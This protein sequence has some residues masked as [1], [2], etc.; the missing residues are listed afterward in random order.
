MTPVMTQLI[1]YLQPGLMRE[2]ANQTDADL[3]NRFVRSRDGLAF[4]LLLWRH[5]AMVWG[6]CRRILGASPDAEDAFQATFVILSRKA[7]TV[8]H[9]PALAGW[10][11][12]V[13]WRTASNARRARGR[14]RETSSTV[15]SFS[16]LRFD[17]VQ[18]AENAELAAIIDA[19]IARLPEP[20]RE[21]FVL[22]ELEGRPLESAARELAIPLGTLNSRL[23]RARSKLRERL[24]SRGVA[25]TTLAIAVVP[26]SMAAAT[27]NI[28]AN[29]I[30]A[31]AL[32]LAAGVSLFV[33]PKSLF[34][35]STTAVMMLAGVGYGAWE[36]VQTQPVPPKLGANEEVVNELAPIDG[37]V[38]AGALARLGSQRLRHNGRVSTMA[39]SP[40]GKLLA[41][42]SLTFE[43]ATA[44]LWDTQTGREVFRVKIDVGRKLI[45]EAKVPHAIG[46]ANGG[47]EFLVAD[48]KGFR[49]FDVT[50]R[51]E[52]FASDYYGGK[53]KAAEVL[54]IA[55]SPDGK[56]FVLT[57]EATGLLEIGDTATGTVLKSI[58]HP[59]ADQKELNIHFTSSGK[60][61]VLTELG[62]E[63]RPFVCDLTTGEQFKTPDGK[64][65][66]VLGTSISDKGDIIVGTYSAKNDAI[67]P[68]LHSFNAKTGG[69]IPGW[70]EGYFKLLIPMQTGNK[71]VVG[72]RDEKK[73]VIL[74]AVTGKRLVDL[75]S[76]RPFNYAALSPDGRYM[77]SVSGY[78]GA[79]QLWDLSSGKALG[80]SGSNREF[81]G[82]CF[83]DGDKALID[84]FT[85]EKWDW[86]ADRLA[87]K[88]NIKRDPKFARNQRIS[89]DGSWVAE[90]TSM[91]DTGFASGPVILTDST[92][93]KIVKV[94]GT[95]EIP[96]LIQTI[97]KNAKRL[98]AVI[99]NVDK[100][101]V[102]DIESGAE[103]PGVPPMGDRHPGSIAMSGNGRYFGV[104]L[105]GE[106]GGVL[107][108]P[109]RVFIWDID[110]RREIGTF[111]TPGENV[112]NQAFTLGG[113]LLAI[114]GGSLQVDVAG[115]CEIPIFEAVSGRMIEKLPSNDDL[116][117]C[118]GPNLEFS[119]D[120]RWLAI[121]ERSG[122]VRLWNVLTGKEHRIEVHKQESAAHF[123]TDG[124]MLVTSAEYD[125]YCYV[126]DLAAITKEEPVASAKF[127]AD[128]TWNELADADA[129]KAFE[130][131]RQLVAN[132][133]PAMVILKAKLKPRNGLDA[134]QIDAWIADLD[135]PKFTDRVRATEEL[136]KVSEWIEPRLIQVRESANAEAKDR[137]NGIIS[138]IGKPSRERLR[139]LR[140]ILALQ[141]IDTP[142]AKKLAAE[143]K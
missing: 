120:S 53:S 99:P 114:G 70:S 91:H 12:R 16:S 9:L 33:V 95:K 113:E 42:M 66:R 129:K 125:P 19:E 118:L 107:K 54:S 3:L 96:H 17:P 48:K 39:W 31:S 4:E 44:R 69:K 59:Y 123:S 85:C 65:G 119:P 80:I 13:A 142:E 50:S 94:L 28:L 25:L 78:S 104:V 27:S 55:F 77:A 108:K 97:S 60:R 36:Y 92:T 89:P 136:R 83:F 26:N 98:A 62:I 34:I 93:G 56:T 100:L 35:A 15:D 88:I 29:A 68:M 7:N 122:M 38:P 81:A 64:E 21:P 8:I 5:S 20:F 87:G 2:S 124:K 140:A 130:A 86:R 63:A 132:P 121:S 143:L 84:S 32:K 90:G 43:D 127:D 14:I 138:T 51:K 46:F 37:P 23:S 103:L 106:N 6:V 11:H 24:Q 18:Q 45:W 133:I 1:G 112:P 111:E 73:S 72:L 128:A 137:L 139:V 40:S 30:P 61:I 47:R 52:L 134:K 126:W 141:Y 67:G 105:D 135:A 22:C 116:K 10:L 131:V 110:A 49:R 75:N 71:I 57:R 82:T 101:F 58:S 79:I 74:D 115:K 41:S 76:D 109:N 102:W 117:N